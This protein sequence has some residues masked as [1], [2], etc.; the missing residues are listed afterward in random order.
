M[1]TAIVCH[2]WLWLLWINRDAPSINPICSLLAPRSLL[3]MVDGLVRGMM[4]PVRGRG[5]GI[6]VSDRLSNHATRASP[7]ASL[8]SSLNLIKLDAGCLNGDR[9]RV[10]LRPRLSPFSG[11]RDLLRGIL[12][13][14][15]RDSVGWFQAVEPKTKEQCSDL[16]ANDL[17]CNSCQEG[18]SRTQ[19]IELKINIC[20]DFIKIKLK[21][22]VVSDIICL[23]D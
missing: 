2:L 10:R 6:G 3:S 14:D 17:M 12:E 11:D 15:I 7:P 1:L 13:L 8:S 16:E 18:L 23:L 22:E 9:A 5:R 19:N 21:R 20:L 4:E